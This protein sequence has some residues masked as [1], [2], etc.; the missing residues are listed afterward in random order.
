MTY[1]ELVREE[2]IGHLKRAVEKRESDVAMAR[3][4]LRAASAHLRR[5]KGELAD[6]IK[7]QDEEG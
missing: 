7:G 5:V 1:V 2:A 3:E 4:D 6:L